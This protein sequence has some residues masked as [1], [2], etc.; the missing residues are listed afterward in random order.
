MAGSAPLMPSLGHGL[1]TIHGKGHR[2]SSKDE[3]SCPNVAAH[4]RFILR[5]RQR[6]C[7]A[8]IVRLPRQ[9]DRESQLTD[10][11]GVADMIGFAVG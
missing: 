5:G 2:S 3:I 9:L 7:S 11:D 1:E 10:F 8:G 4:R 6:D